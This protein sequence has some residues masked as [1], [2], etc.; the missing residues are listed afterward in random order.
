MP[1][2]LPLPGENTPKKPSFMRGAPYSNQEKKPR[3]TK[4]KTLKQ[5]TTIV[6]KEQN[7][8][9]SAGGVIGSSLTDDHVT[10]KNRYHSAWRGPAI[11]GSGGCRG[12]GSVVGWS[13]VVCC[14]D[15]V[16]GARNIITRSPATREVGIPA[17]GIVLPRGCGDGAKLPQAQGPE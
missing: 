14:F 12:E 6:P 7:K 9:C 1:S 4:N 10:A 16:E 17:C 11:C 8:T 13:L 15:G 5:I 2:P 3:V